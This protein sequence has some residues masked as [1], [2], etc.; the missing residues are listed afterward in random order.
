[1][2]GRSAKGERIK[3]QSLL[4]LCLSFGVLAYCNEVLAKPLVRI[5]IVR[6][7]LHGLPEFILGAGP[8]PVVQGLHPSQSGVAA[9]QPAVNF[10]CFQCGSFRFWEGFLWRQEVPVCEQDVGIGPSSTP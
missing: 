6:A 8:I 1:M 3:L 7:E 2:Y 9:G 5:G 4:E 10:N